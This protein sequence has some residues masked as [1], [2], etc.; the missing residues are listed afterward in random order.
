MHDGMVD[1]IRTG[2]KELEDAI[3]H[4]V[5]DGI[6]KRDDRLLRT[7]RINLRADLREA[8]KLSPVSG[9]ENE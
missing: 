4:R 5:G 7:L 8:T 6:G 9:I 3:K 2:V 1:V